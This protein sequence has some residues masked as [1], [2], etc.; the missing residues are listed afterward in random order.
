MTES[1]ILA[2][3]DAKGISRI[4]INRPEMRNALNDVVIAE[5]QAALD[6][7]IADSAVRAI[8]ITGAGKAFSAGGDLGAMKNTTGEAGKLG[9]GLP[10]LMQSIRKAPKPVI[11]LVNGA[12][13]GGAL[14][15]IAACDIAIGADDAKFSFSEA[16]LGLAP[17]MISPYVVEAIGARNARRFFLTGERFDAATAKEIGLL[18]LTAPAADLETTLAEVAGNITACG[19]VALA[20]CKA[21]IA[22]VD[23]SDIS[24]ALMNDLAALIARLR[25]SEEGQEGIAA[26]LQKRKPSW[27]KD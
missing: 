13:F 17:A 20:E 11:A 9:G 8:I 15:L 24:N 10:D 21:L 25:A 3:V 6:A 12:A 5:M 18:H 2:N 7:F 26:F 23:G 22:K 4:T 16:R 1:L 19:P 14:G 27:M